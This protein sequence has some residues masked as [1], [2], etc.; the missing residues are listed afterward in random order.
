MAKVSGK[1]MTAEEQRGDKAWFC[2]FGGEELDVKL[3]SDP[4]GKLACPPCTEAAGE[5]KSW[6]ATLPPS[7]EDVAKHQDDFKASAKVRADAHKAA[8]K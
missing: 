4:S 2:Q 6:W 7:A 5:P 8:K 3:P 1:K